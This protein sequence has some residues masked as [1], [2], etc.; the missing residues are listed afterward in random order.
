MPYF[1]GGYP[2]KIDEKNRLAICSALRE[3]MNPE[4][5]GSNFFLVLGKDSRLWLYPES[6]F[7]RLISKMK[8]SSKPAAERDALDAWFASARLVKPDSQGRVVL[9]EPILSQANVPSDVTLVGNRDHIEI[10]STAEHEQRMAVDFAALAEM[11][12]AAAD[13]L[14]DETE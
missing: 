8:R 5:D 1:V 7:K 2:Q 13:A 9:P 12:D 14:C 10:W 4:T 6:Y 3:L 11:V